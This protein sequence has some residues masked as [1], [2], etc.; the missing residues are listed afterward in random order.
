[1]NNISLDM[2]FLINNGPPSA[3]CDPNIKPKYVQWP[4]PSTNGLDV[5]ATAP[6]ILADD[7]PCRKPGRINGITV[8]GSWLDD[9]VDTNV[10]FQLGLWT[11]VPKQPGTGNY[12]HPGQLLCTQTFYPPTSAATSLL[13]YKAS[14]AVANVLEQFYD[15]NPPPPGLIGID[16]QIWRYDF[17][18][19]LACWRQDGGLTAQKVYWLSLVATTTN[20]FLFGWKTTTNHW[21]DDAVFGHV[22]N[23]IPVGDWLDLHDPRPLRTNISLDLSFALRTF[24]I[25]GVNKDLINTTQQPAD[26]V[27]I[28]IAGIREVTAHYDDPPSP[29]PNF[30]A[31]Y[32]GGNTALQWTGKTNAPGALTH[33]GAEMAGNSLNIISMAWLQ[34]PAV[35]GIPIQL[36]HRILGNGTVLVLANNFVP[37]PVI[38]AGGFIEY[39]TNATPLDVMKPNGPRTPILTVPLPI[40]PTAVQPG[41]VMRIPLQQQTPPE[42]RYAMLHVILNDEHGTFATEDFLQLPLDRE[43]APYINQAGLA[44]SFFDVFFDVIP[45]R[46]YRVRESPTLA[47][48]SF[49]DIFIE[50]SFE[51]NEGKVTVPAPGRKGFIRI[52]LDAE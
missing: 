24:P 49:F 52:M 14:L 29:W 22:A 39:F 46:T 50:L 5:K 18:P 11:D 37:A 6:N 12:S 21:N 25:V 27:R 36:N 15:P 4:D 44:D 13:R 28:V 32:D 19:N 45:G 43:L 40:S 16:T 10:V 8:W 26:G 17:Y 33:V 1:M 9:N 3:D 35:V 41:G 48:D 23:G 30:Q 31:S 47:A 7:F 20:G 42:A 38:V 2:A 51:E 34:G